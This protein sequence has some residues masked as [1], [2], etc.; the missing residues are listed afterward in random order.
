MPKFINYMYQRFPL[1]PL[2]ILSLSVVV[3]MGALI[4]NGDVTFRLEE[5]S[6][7]LI[8]VLFLFHMRILDE[9]KDYNFDAVNFPDRPLHSGLVSKKDLLI[10]EI[11]CVILIGFI[12]MV[13]TNFIS[14]LFL[15]VSFAYSGFMFKEFFIE[16]FW[17]KSAFLYLAS[18]QVILFLV[19]L[20]VLTGLHENILYNVSLI[21]I[22]AILIH[23]F[24]PFLAIELGRKIKHRIDQ[25]G[26]NTSDTYAQTWGQRNTILIIFFSYVIN[27]CLLLYASQ[28]SITGLLVF[29]TIISLYLLYS[30]VA[31]TSFIEN[32]RA[33]TFVMSILILFCVLL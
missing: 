13:F 18:H 19:L 26:N 3:V 27:L 10:Y 12:S 9:F 25:Q 17:N 7:G 14:F 5:I 23:A 6:I 24:M 11:I 31:K 29:G 20:C 15:I 8:P 16:D 33:V 30:Y 2:Y 21:H 1:I 28:I 22:V 4:N 32:S